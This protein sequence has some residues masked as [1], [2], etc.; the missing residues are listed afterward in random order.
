MNTTYQP[1][2]IISNRYCIV[3]ILGE[4]GTAVTYEA[5]N[6]VNNSYAYG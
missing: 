6:L 2:D 3:S 4:G 5:V 1:G